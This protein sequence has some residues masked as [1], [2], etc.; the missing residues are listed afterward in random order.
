MLSI[1]DLLWHELETLK[2]FFDRAMSWAST[3]SDEEC[4][5]LA[6]IDNPDNDTI[7]G[8]VT[9]PHGAHSLKQVAIRSVVNELNSLCEFALQNTWVTVSKQYN[10]PN[11]EFIYTATRGNIEKALSVQEVRVEEWPRWQ[12]VL[13]IKEMSEGFKHRQRMQPFPLE[14]QKRGFEWRAARVVDPGNQEML[15]EYDPTPSQAREFLSA[16]EELLLWLQRNYAL[17]RRS[18]SLLS[19]AGRCAIKPR[20]AG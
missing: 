4:A 15:A 3:K 9:D 14:L 20:S 2:S 1:S 16:I 8:V 17:T 12:Q 11:G 18:T 7:E 13:E 19:V 10:L 6:E 5:R